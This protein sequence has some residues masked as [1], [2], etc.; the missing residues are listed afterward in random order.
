MPE[1]A[2]GLAAHAARL[3]VM[4]VAGLEVLHLEEHGFAISAHRDGHD[5]LRGLVDL[6]AAVAG[7]V[8]VG[9]RVH[10]VARVVA[11]GLGIDLLGKGEL[12]AVLLDPHLVNLKG[13]FSGPAGALEAEGQSAPCTP[14]AVGGAHEEG[15]IIGETKGNDSGTEAVEEGEGHALVDPVDFLE[16]DAM[17]LRVGLLAHQDLSREGAK[18]ALGVIRDDAGG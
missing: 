5:L 17:H 1:L 18:G 4:G 7:L 6:G 14:T 3:E 16:E 10:R 13:H 8:N 2:A 9:P 12:E 15:A 11:G